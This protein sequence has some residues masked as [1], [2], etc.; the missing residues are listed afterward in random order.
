MAIPPSAERV[1]WAELD[2]ASKERRL[3]EAAEQV[4]ARNGLAA[5]VP[6]IAAAA[7]AGVGSVYRLFG[8]KDEIVAALAVQRLSWFEREAQ[9]ALREAD[10]GSAL[11]S[12]LRAVV[13]RDSVDPVLSGALQAAFERPEVAPARAAAR[14]AWERLLA[15]AAEQGSFRA[16]LTPDDLRLLLL[17]TRAAESAAPGTGMRLLELALAGLRTSR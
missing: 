2:A 11:E 14:S 4:F 3:L 12:L 10:A 8:S 7:G 9:A 13:A 17:G 1:P 6:A 15:R 16:G 5:P